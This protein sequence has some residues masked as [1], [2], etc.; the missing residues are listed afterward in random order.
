MP[1][2]V[3]YVPKFD[4]FAFLSKAMHRNLY[5]GQITP[6][7]SQKPRIGVGEPKALAPKI[8]QYLS[9]I[10]GIVTFYFCLEVL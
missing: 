7:T 1:H 8:L 2:N 4:F 10:L 3:L 6:K 5:L 9:D